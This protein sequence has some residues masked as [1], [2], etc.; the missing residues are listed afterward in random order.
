MV[1]SYTIYGHS[2]CA[3]G[4]G[5]FCLQFIVSFDLFDQT[6]LGTNMNVFCLTFTNVI[7]DQGGMY[8]GSWGFIP[9]VVCSYFLFELMNN[10]WFN[11]A[12]ENVLTGPVHGMSYPVFGALQQTVELSSC[13]WKQISA[14]QSLSF[15]TNQDSEC[16]II[17]CINLAAL[18]TSHWLRQ[19]LSWWFG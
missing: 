1:F 8:F 6:E 13:L 14:T 11:S 5:P 19:S 16:W 12:S 3:F 7:L 15:Q 9:W 17:M 10:R 2:E 18:M 4:I